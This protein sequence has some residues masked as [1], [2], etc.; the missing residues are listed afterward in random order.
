MLAEEED[1]QNSLRAFRP[2]FLNDLI[3]LGRD[4]DGG[5]VV[6]E[7]AIRLSRYLL[8]FG[9]NDDW[10][11]EASFRNRNPDAQ[12]F[13]F[14]HSVS[15]DVLREKSID[16]L[17]QILS[18]R[19]V[20]GALSLNFRGVRNKFRA[21]KR[22]IKLHSDFSSFFFSSN[23]RLFSRGV[24]NVNSSKF[25]T[26]SEIFQMIPQDQL[27]VENSVFVKMDI[28]QSE[29]RVFPDLLK[30]ERC[31]NGLVIEFHDLDILWPNFVNVMNQMK[32]KFEITHLHG[33]NFCELIPNCRTPKLLEI[34][35]L[36]RSLI[37]DDEP[38][39]RAVVYPIAGLDQPNDRSKEDYPLC[40]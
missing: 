31:L 18:A 33:N 8:S 2:K 10:S 12:I 3:R 5:Y 24:S 35:F 32:V 40:F 16:A 36:K 28:E 1:L 6:N 38:Q 21:L 9:V 26:V 15:K 22:S 14:D 29:F 19:F 37:R 23:V 17:N 30:F 27:D 20:L 39:H 11:F 13:C 25:F 4:S 34:T 7:R